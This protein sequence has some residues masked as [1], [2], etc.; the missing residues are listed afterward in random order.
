MSVVGIT[1]ST[2]SQ[3]R[4]TVP[5]A[6]ER[7]GGL[8]IKPGD[9]VVVKINLCEFRMP[10]SGAITR[11]DF[12]D[13]LLSYLRSR[14]QP[15][16]I[17][18]V[19][20]DATAARP[21][22]ISQWLGVDT[23]LRKHNVEWANLSRT[24]CVVK[25]IDGRHFERLKISDLI[26]RC[27]YL[28]S[29][30]KM[31]THSLTTVTC[32]LKNQFGCIP[33]RRKIKY[34][35]FLDDAIVDA[36]LAMKPDYSIVDG[37]I[38]LGGAKGPDLGVPVRANVIVTGT[39][40]VSVDAT[41]ARIMGFTPRLIGHITKAAGAGVGRLSATTVGEAVSSVR[42]NFEFNSLYHKAL[43]IAMSLRDRKTG[44]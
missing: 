4:R 35:P 39:D 41:C 24:R 7:A 26:D 28:I 20:S 37:I 32:S 21:D 16:E 19:E 29:L 10:E 27:D 5:T 6:I 2:Y 8:N 1:R 33:Y 14:F 13:A 9:T 11:P 40:P 12:L 42:T 18:V 22:M 17:Y 15:R 23:V 3:V 36:C 34:H 30:A 25:R 44:W 43:K 31:K 38:G